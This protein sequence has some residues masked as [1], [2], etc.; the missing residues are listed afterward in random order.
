MGQGAAAVLWYSRGKYDH[1]FPFLTA[2]L[3]IGLDSRLHGYTG[4]VGVPGHFHPL[5]HNLLCG[6]LQ[7]AVGFG[8]Y[9]RLGENSVGHALVVFLRVGEAAL[10]QKG[11]VHL[12]PNSVGVNEGSVHV[13]YQHKFVLSSQN[14][15]GKSTASSA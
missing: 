10:F 6:L 12:P 9:R 14:L 15:Q 7:I 3:Q 13:K 1:P 2:L 5:G 8:K 4:G 11:D